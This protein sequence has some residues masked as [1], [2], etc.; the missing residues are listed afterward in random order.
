M[1]KI[2]EC[3]GIFRVNTIRCRYVVDKEWTSEAID[4]LATNMCVI[5][6]GSWL[7]HDELIDE[8]AAGLNWALSHHCWSVRKSCVDLVKPVEMNGCGLVP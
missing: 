7:I 3:Q 8:G 6:V 4:V 5:P 2:G 1:V